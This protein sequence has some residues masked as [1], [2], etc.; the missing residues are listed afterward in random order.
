[1]SVGVDMTGGDQIANAIRTKL[2]KTSAAIG[3]VTIGVVPG[4]R[5]GAAKNAL[6]AQVQKAQQRD[7]WYLDKDAMTAIRFLLRGA[8]GENADLGAIL[9]QIGSLMVDATRRN[10]ENQR[11]PGGAT[12]RELT[13]RYAAFKRRKYGFTHPI[14]KATSDLIDGLKAVIT[15][16]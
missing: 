10:I 1:M 15:K 12:F 4:G 14:L 8:G 7:P 6:I 5:R 3:T 9:R 11:G 16:Q 2:L 13:A